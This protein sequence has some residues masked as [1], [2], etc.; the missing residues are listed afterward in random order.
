MYPSIPNSNTYTKAITS[1]N[2]PLLLFLF[3]SLAKYLLSFSIILLPYALSISF[4]T[5]SNGKESKGLAEKRFLP[6]FESET[7]FDIH[8]K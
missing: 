1:Q 5:V 6:T 8:L 4:S 3:I 2:Y 7:K